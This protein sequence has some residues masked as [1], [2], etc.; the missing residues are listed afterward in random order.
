[1]DI[2]YQLVELLSR[3]L[4]RPNTYF[5]ADTRLLGA[6]AD[7]DSMAL[8][9]LLTEI[10]HCFDVDILDAEFD[11]ETFYSVSTLTAFIDRLRPGV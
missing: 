3:I 7:F 6:M 2:Q 4:S 5:E 11:S 9:L 1:M 10:S 8:M